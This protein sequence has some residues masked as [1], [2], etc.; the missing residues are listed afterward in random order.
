MGRSKRDLLVDSWLS[1]GRRDWSKRDLI[2]WPPD[3]DQCF[4]VKLLGRSCEVA[5]QHP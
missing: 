5:S 2:R 1:A 3:P 4:K